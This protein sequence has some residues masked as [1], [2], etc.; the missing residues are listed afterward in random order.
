MPVQN[1][2]EA[3]LVPSMRV[4]SAEALGPLI[5]W[6][7][8]GD[9]EASGLGVQILDSGA[10]LAV[11]VPAGAEAGPD[12]D[13]ADVVGQPVARR[14]AEICAAGGHHMLLL[15]PLERETRYLD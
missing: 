2:A 6:L 11:P 14:A 9:P 4:I 8:A 10:G 15:G 12:R 3:A 7:R 13:L 5:G 1:A